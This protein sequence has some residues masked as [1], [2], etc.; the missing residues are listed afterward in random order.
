MEETKA[1]SEAPPVIV[2]NPSTTSAKVADISM[3]LEA[4]P[5]QI[6]EGRVILRNLPFD[7]KE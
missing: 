4:P 2:E 6:K 3:P 7:I 1:I 5:P